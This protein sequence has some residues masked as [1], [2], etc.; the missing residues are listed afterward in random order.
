MSSA[1]AYSRARRISCGSC[2]P[3]PSSVNR[4]TPAAASSPN[5]ASALPSRFTVMH[6]AGW[7]SHRPARRGLRSHELDHRQRVLRRLGVGHRH[8]RGEPAE[9]G[10]ATAGL[11]R[12]GVLPTGLAQVHVEVDETRSDDAVRRV[13]VVVAVQRRHRPR[14]PDH[15]STA[16]SARR[17]PVWSSTVPPRITMRLTTRHPSS[18]SPIRVVGTALP[19]ARRRRW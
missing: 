9:R 12:L 18:R 11:D 3:L 13:E 6:P 16:T 7:T 8:D 1:L 15:R 5:G 14:R 19:C 4:W 2:T 17:S 10:G